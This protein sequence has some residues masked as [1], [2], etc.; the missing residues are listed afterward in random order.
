MLV[1]DAASASALDDALWG[2]GGGAWLPH[3]AYPAADPRTPL[4]PIWITDD[5][6]TL[7]AGAPNGARLLFLIGGAAVDSASATRH[8]ARFERIF[9]L[10][11][12]A[13]APALKAARARWREASGLGLATVYWRET[14]SGWEQAG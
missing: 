8:H 14:R 5:D 3:G 6:A 11:D 10:F 9:D 13:S 7:A 1:P 4:C 2:E 12:G